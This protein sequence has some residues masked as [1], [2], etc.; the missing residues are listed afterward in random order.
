M[1]KGAV[2]KIAV[3]TGLIVMMGLSTVGAVSMYKTIEGVLRPDIKVKV[4]GTEL[5]LKDVNGKKITPLIVEG[6]T[7]LPVRTIAD[8]VGMNV[9]WDDKTQTV[10]LNE[11]KP[12]ENIGIRGIVKNIVKGKDGITF[13]VEG[14]KQIDTLYDLGTITVNRDTILENVESYSDIKEGA[15]VEVVL[16]E[17][18]T[19]IYPIQ[20]P[21]VKLKVINN[22]EISVRGVVKEI[23]KGKDGLT[24][25]VEGSKENNTI[26]DKARVTVNLKTIMENITSFNE[27]QEGDKVEV[28]LNS[29]VTKSYPVM[30]AA[31]T[32]KEINN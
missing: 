14:K 25:L 21:A 6:S 32:I 9:T 31:A 20:S 18:I 13:T 19:Q 2:S 15:V 3:S 11:T 23:E 28:K 17:F 7:Y 30:G 29:N 12:I 8:A 10:N 1:K 26:Y 5:D 22:N 24:F 27:I 16:P 4:E